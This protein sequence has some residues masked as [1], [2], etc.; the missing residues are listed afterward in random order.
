MPTVLIFL[1]SVALGLVEGWLYWRLLCRLDRGKSLL[2]WSTVGKSEDDTAIM[3]L[4]GCAFF[5]PT[6]VL[7]TRGILSLASAQTED[8]SIYYNSCAVGAVIFAATVS[9]CH[10]RVQH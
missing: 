5:L 9:V 3:A 2:P 8:G 4:V 6:V 1:A 7:L 10:R